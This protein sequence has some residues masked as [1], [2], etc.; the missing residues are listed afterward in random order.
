[1]AVLLMMKRHMTPWS[2]TIIK[3]KS[4]LDMLSGKQRRVWS[5]GEQNGGREA[6]A[7]VQMGG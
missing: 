6:L 2:R 1:M 4:M 3:A 7:L 5:G